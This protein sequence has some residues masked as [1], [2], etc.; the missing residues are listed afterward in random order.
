MTKPI[1]AIGLVRFSPR[2]N[3]DD[4]ESLDKQIERIHEY[5]AAKG[6]RVLRIYQEPDTSGGED[7]KGDLADILDRRPTLEQALSEIKR[8]QVLLVR[9]RSRIGRSVFLMQ[10]VQRELFRKGC[11]L[12]STD[13]PNGELPAD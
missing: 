8:G 2:P 11:S 5:A 13:E 10:Y 4:C 7:G 9:W 12:E 1:E 6:Y 3:P